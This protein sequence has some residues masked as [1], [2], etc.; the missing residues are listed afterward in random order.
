[1]H[2]LKWL[3]ECPEAI[4][5]FWEKYTENI[6]IIQISLL[7]TQSSSGMKYL[8]EISFQSAFLQ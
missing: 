7:H 2:L 8:L 5:I 4:I 3:F 1:M 6:E